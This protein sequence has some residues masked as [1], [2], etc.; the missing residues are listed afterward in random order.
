MKALFIL[1]L[2][3]AM[4]NGISAQDCT[5][6]YY[7]QN[8]KTTEITMFDKKGKEDG[9]MLY[10]ASSVNKSG[11]TTTATVNFEFLDKKGKSTIKS[12]NNVKCSGGSLMMDMKMFMSPQQS[13]QMKADVK[14]AEAYLTYPPNMKVGDALPNG[15]FKADIKQGN[16]MSSSVEV[17]IT[18]R[19]VAA[20]ESVTT[21]A[22]T[23]NCFKIT[24]NSKFRMVMMGVGIPIKADVTEWF[25]PAFGVVK[26]E[27]KFGKTELTAIK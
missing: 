23:W 11:N 4:G 25:A 2:T 20:Q 14:S 13:E 1:F 6:Y 15:S 18:E 3:A 8:G 22:G 27:S 24:Y 19:K 16:G 17:D 5:S 10:T 12:V 7:L 21:P 26:T 9:K